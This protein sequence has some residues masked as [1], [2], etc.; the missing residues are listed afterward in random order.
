MDEP[1][2]RVKDLKLEDEQRREN[3]GTR[4]EVLW[5]KMQ[6]GKSLRATV[7]LQLFL[8]SLDSRRSPDSCL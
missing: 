2:G 1:G 7:H 5:V 3:V 8:A 4:A 6:A